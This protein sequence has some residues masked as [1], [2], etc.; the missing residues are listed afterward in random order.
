MPDIFISEEKKEESKATAPTKKKKKK[1]HKHSHRKPFAYGGLQP[2]LEKKPLS[3]FIFYPRGIDFETRETKEEVILF[4]RKHHI[5]NVP[6]ILG[7]ALLLLVP[8]FAGQLAILE[9][10]PGNFV[11][12]FTLMWYLFCLIFFIE[13]FLTWYFN[14][15]IVTDERIIDFD[16]YHLIYK[17]V[18]EAKIDKIQDVNY[19]SVGV[20][21]TIFDMGDVL[22]QT[23]SEI[24]NLDFT[25][26]P[27]P[28]KVVRVLQD[29]RTE[30]EQEAIEGRVR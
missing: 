14:V 28:N 9:S 4:L 21:R 29:L 2:M 15:N 3:S 16:F 12:I 13:K 18:T 22:I 23:A 17:D 6:W 20:L 10:V 8:V 1:K 26:I 30:E 27:K 11:F 24:P 19:K 25:A 5:T 7:L